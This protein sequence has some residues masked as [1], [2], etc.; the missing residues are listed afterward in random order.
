MFLSKISKLISNKLIY[1]VLVKI[2]KLFSIKQFIRINEIKHLTERVRRTERSLQRS[3]DVLQC[4][5]QRELRFQSLAKN[6]RLAVVKGT[7]GY[8]ESCDGEKAFV[9]EKGL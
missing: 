1:K 2:P 6:C 9:G 8:I 3:D 5:L 7:A 4:R